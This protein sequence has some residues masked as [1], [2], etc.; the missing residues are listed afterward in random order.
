MYRLV[1]ERAKSPATEVLR[2]PVDEVSPSP[3]AQALTNNDRVL[4]YLAH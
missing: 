1:G 3:I 2:R 4:F